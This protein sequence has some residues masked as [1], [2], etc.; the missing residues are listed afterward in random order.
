MRYRIVPVTPFR[1][2]CSLLWCPDSLA[3]AVVD[4]GGE[5]DLIQAAIGEEGV[6]V[7]KIL[8]THGHADHAGGAAELS[9][10]LGVPI[11]GPHPDDA[12]LI[13]AM[14][15]QAARTGLAEA[16]GFTPSRWLDD[17]G[18]VQVGQLSLSV[19]H[20]PGHTPGHIVFH[21]AASKLAVVGDVLF[22]GSIGR[23]DG[24]R[25]DHIQLVNAIRGK[26]WP[27]GNDTEFIPGHGDMSSFAWERASNAYVCDFVE[28]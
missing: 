27:L 11:E 9:E 18:V 17:G 3:A 7:E 4:P 22:R 20:C 21:H 1:Q 28:Y 2:N 23:C 15:K 19:L 10:R 14:A 6:R 8:I 5:L 25:G 16:R 12:F 24:P 13:E 26:L